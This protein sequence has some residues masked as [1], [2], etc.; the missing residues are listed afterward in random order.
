MNQGKGGGRLVCS[1]QEM[2]VNGKTKVVG[3]LGDP[4]SHSLSPAMHNAAYRAAG[5]N[6]CYLPFCVSREKI[7]PAMKAVVSLGLQGVNIT[8]PHKEAAGKH[9]D[10]LSPEASFLKAVNT[11]KNTAGRL[12]G[13][14]TDVA[15]FV[16]LLEKNFGKHVFAGQKACLWGAGGAA[17]AVALALSR[18]GVRSLV[19]I[20]RTEAHA[21]VLAD[22]LARGGVFRAGDICVL[23]LGARVSPHSMAGTSLLINALSVDPAGQDLIPLENMPG[24]RAAV[25]LRYNPPQTAFMHQAKE[26]G[27]FAL[28]GLDML[29]GQGLQA[30]EIFTGERAL[31]AVMRQALLQSQ[32]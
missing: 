30:F 10:E 15:G 24:C 12:Y 26:R 7:G 20:N 28:N 32:Q 23:K 11:V 22:L 25:D 3:L 2:P 29:L 4:V 1:L 16:Y 14:N 13:Y 6:F 9:L 21:K 5:L 18:V 8:A 19:I 17:R 27:I 31:P